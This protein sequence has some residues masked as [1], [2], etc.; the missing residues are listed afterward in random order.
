[1][2]ILELNIFIMLLFKRRNRLCTI[3]LHFRIVENESKNN[4][5]LI[6]FLRILSK[7]KEIKF[8]ESHS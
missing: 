4:Y 1:M 8:V 3:L 7:Y 6:E 2:N 5:R